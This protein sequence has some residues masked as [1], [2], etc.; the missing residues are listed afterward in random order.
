MT[1]E[2]SVR[3]QD[4]EGGFWGIVTDDN[5]NFRPAGELPSDVKT[6]G[7]RVKAEVEPANVLSFTMWGEI[8]NILSIEKL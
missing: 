2:G 4:F 8:V 6:D 7:C 1:I 5:K 3:Y